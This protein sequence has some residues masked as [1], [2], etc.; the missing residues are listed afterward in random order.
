MRLVLLRL[1]A[2]L[3]AALAGAA[4]GARHVTLA[5]DLVV[6][7]LTAVG[8]VDGVRSA[9]LWGLVGG[10]LVDLTP[11]GAAVLGVGALLHALGGAVAGRGRREDRVTLPWVVLVAGAVALAV[12][13]GRVL[14]AA[15]AGEPVDLLV[16]LARVVLTAATAGLVVPLLRRLED[17]AERRP[18]RRP[19]AVRR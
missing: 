11:P 2:L 18:A 12:T 8:V 6:A 14:L 17:G 19:A 5:P 7:V 15:W 1:L 3:V 10:W 16:G 9:T 13:A 4:L